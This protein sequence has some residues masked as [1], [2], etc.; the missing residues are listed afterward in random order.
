MIVEELSMLAADS[1]RTISLF[2][3]DFCGVFC[4]WG[5]FSLSEVFLWWSDL[6]QSDLFLCSAHTHTLALN[7]N[8]LFLRYQGVNLCLFLPFWLGYKQARKKPEVAAGNGKWLQKYCGRQSL[9]LRIKCSFLSNIR[10]LFWDLWWQGRAANFVMNKILRRIALDV[11]GQENN[12][13]ELLMT[14]TQST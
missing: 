9:Q 12:P 1:V 4:R 7:S 3:S 11:T 6:F 2:G 8:L 14:R 5:D 13:L 10:M